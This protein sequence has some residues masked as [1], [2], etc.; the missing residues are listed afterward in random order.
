MRGSSLI[1]G[2]TL[3]ARCCADLELMG[4]NSEFREAARLLDETVTALTAVETS[5][6]EGSARLYFR[7]RG[8]RRSKINFV[9]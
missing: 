1:V 4:R 7:L 5:W 6:Q 9:V 8:Q 3:V 2:G